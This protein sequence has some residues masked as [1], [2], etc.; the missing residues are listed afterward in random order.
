MPF[1]L[2]NHAFALSVMAFS[3]T[4]ALAIARRPRGF[5]RRKLVFWVVGLIFCGVWSSFQAMASSLC[6]AVAGNLVSNCGFETGDFTSWTIGGNTL[7][8]GGNYYGVDAFDANSGRFGAYISQD[9]FDGDKAPVDLSETMSTTAGDIYS[10]TFYLEQ[11][12]AP[13]TG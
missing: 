2:R 8:P 7:N 13:K 11:D 1:S 10:F 4:S 3:A 9:F 6:T 12:T 5:R